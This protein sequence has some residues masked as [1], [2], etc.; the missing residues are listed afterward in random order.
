MGIYNGARLHKTFSFSVNF[1]HYQKVYLFKQISKYLLH[2]IECKEH[3]TEE[4]MSLLSL[5]FSE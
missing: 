5:V 2:S 1:D 3:V 4:K